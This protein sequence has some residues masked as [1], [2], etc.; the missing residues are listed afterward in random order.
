MHIRICSELLHV[1][2]LILKVAGNEWASK[3]MQNQMLIVLCCSSAQESEGKG[4]EIIFYD[5]LFHTGK[6]IK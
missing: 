1:R 6:Q 2:A 5:N 4:L 3:H